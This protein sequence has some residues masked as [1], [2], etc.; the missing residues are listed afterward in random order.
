MET[1]EIFQFEIVIIVLIIAPTNS[2]EYHAMGLRPLDLFQFFQRGDRLYTSSQ[3][4]MYTDVR[5]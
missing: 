3:S 5:F 4:L 2:F 1:K